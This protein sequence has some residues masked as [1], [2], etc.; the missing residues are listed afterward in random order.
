[1]SAAAL[2]VVAAVLERDGRVLVAR[3]PAGKADAGLWEFPGGKC[4]PG[5]GAIDALRR[6]LREELGIT[7]TAA[8]P[9]IRVPVQRASGRLWLDTWRVSAWQGEPRALEHDRLA[10]EDP[11]VLPNWPMPPADRPVVV[12]LTSPAFYAIT[13]DASEG[14]GRFLD[15]LGAV[16]DAGVTRVQLRLPGLSSPERHAAVAAVLKRFGRG[17]DWL[18]NGDA[19]VA[20]S[21]GIGLHLPSTQLQALTARP[22]PNRAGRLLAASCHDAGE[23]QHAEALGCDFAVLGPLRPTPTHP[24]QPGLGWQAFADCRASVTLPVLALGG[25]GP[26]D[27]A[28]ARQYGAHGVAGIR[29]WWPQPSAGSAR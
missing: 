26:A 5:E 13:P 9:L 11:A 25:V 8:E 14:I 27:L 24:G 17:I 28:L 18:V 22:F 10:W 6:E 3:R 1:M 2:H 4:E 29:A 15:A 19:A 16:L 23:L 7:V 21:L 12:A 20:E